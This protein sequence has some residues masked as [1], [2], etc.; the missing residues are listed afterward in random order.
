LIVAV[1]VSGMVACTAGDD[2]VTGEPGAPLRGLRA[3][4]LARFRAGQVLFDKVYLPAEG[5]GPAFNENQCSA[6]HTVP[7]SGG[8]TGFERVVKATR[9]TKPASCD[10]LGEGGGENIRRQATPLLRGR[11]VA[12][13]S[14]PHRATEVGRFLPPALFGLGLVEAIS[15]ETILAA[16]DPDDADRDGISG[17][18]ARTVDGRLARFGRKGDFATIQE[19][20]ESALRLE[21]GLTTPGAPEEPRINGRPVPAGIDPAPDPEIEQSTLHLLTAFVRFL[22]AAAPA[23]PR[24][25]AHA[26]TLTAGRRL[27]TEVG[28]AACHTPAMRTRA[29]GVLPLD[30]KWV[31][32]YSDLLLHDMGA[33]LADVCGHAASPA[34]IRTEPLMGLRHR[35]RFLHD[36]RTGDLREAVL[37][38]GGEGERSR[39][40]FARLSWLRQHQLLTF[41]HSL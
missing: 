8:T 5:L 24:S 28:C 27:F 13:E 22:A 36:G 23:A 16:A 21:M 14:I 29:S 3:A 10:R 18:A 20:I 32:L 1:L 17:R 33:R 37:A 6:C 9:F 12:R 38:H 26:D 35:S 19:F 11:G 25:A 31:G 4:E 34:E 2:A 41:L 39:R 40:T 7:A 30:R 15:D